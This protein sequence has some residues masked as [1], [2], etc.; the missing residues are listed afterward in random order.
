[1]DGE[2]LDPTGWRGTACIFDLP[3][4]RGLAEHGLMQW[5]PALRSVLRRDPALRGL[6][7]HAS[8]QHASV[9]EVPWRPGSVRIVSRAAV[10]VEL[11]VACDPR[12]LGVALRRIALRQGTRFH[13]I[14]AAD[15]ALTEGFYPFEQD[16]G[17][18]WTDGDAA[19]AATLFEGFDGPF[20]LVLHVGGTTR[21]PSL[22][23]PGRHAAAA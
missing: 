1:V 4:K 8:V 19:I 13:L 9:R 20:E 5:D 15:A 6:L 2:R 23:T 12:L 21:Y 14:E 16:N 11:G 18:R 17:L 7:Q 10:P 22:G 3:G